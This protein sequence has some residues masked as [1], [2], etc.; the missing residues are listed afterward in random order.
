MARIEQNFEQTESGITPGDDIVAD[1]GVGRIFHVGELPIDAGVS[2]FGTWQVTSQAGEDADAGRYRYF[3]A[4]PEANASLT[5][6]LAL[7]FRAQWE[8]GAQNVIRGNNLWVILNY[9]W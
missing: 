9:R 6:H 1:W 7:R 4:G 5:K 2:G 8:F 3:G